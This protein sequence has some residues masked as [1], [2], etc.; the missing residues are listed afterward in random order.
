V[1]GAAGGASADGAQ[2]AETQPKE[3]GFTLAES[4][5]QCA[6]LEAEVEKLRLVMAALNDAGATLGSAGMC[7]MHHASSL[8]SSAHIQRTRMTRA[9][10]GCALQED[11]LLSACENLRSG[12]GGEGGGSGARG[13]LGM[14]GILGAAVADVV[15]GKVIL[16]SSQGPPVAK[17]VEQ[18]FNPSSSE[19]KLLTGADARM[20][21]GLSRR[22]R[23]W[24][25]RA[26]KRCWS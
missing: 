8:A 25:A 7:V 21:V 14:P 20:L 13:A 9:A 26:G 1:R 23:W 19:I 22:R 18:E 5:N 10:P 4:K 15:A 6:R 3:G 11:L 2:T 24:V 16:L 12:E 17:A